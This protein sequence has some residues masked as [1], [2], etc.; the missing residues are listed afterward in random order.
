MLSNKKKINLTLTPLYT[1]VKLQECTNKKILKL[2][3][4]INLLKKF[5]SK[6]KEG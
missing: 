5:N 3:K 6:T 4:S 2:K 1:P